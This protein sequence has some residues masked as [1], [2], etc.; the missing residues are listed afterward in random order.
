MINQQSPPP[1][2]GDELYN[3]S[4]LFDSDTMILDYNS[5]QELYVGALYYSDCD[6]GDYKMV[7]TDIS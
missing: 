6:D 1:L 5:S 2:I 4:D 7:F 3:G